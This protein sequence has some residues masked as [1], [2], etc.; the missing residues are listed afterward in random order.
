MDFFGKVLGLG[1]LEIAQAW[2]Q[3]FSKS[4][5]VL[6]PRKFWDSMSCKAVK[7][8]EWDEF[9]IMNLTELKGGPQMPVMGNG[10]GSRK[11]LVSTRGTRRVFM[12]QIG[13]ALTKGHLAPIWFGL[14]SSLAS[15][16][17]N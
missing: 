11:T 9:S 13:I 17:S 15:F 2:G 1:I 14:M 10:A 5:Y 7:V 4:R 3:L 12:S 6:K 16:R 8:L